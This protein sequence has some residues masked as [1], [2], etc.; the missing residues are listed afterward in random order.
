[1]SRISKQTSAVAVFIVIM[2]SCVVPGFGDEGALIDH[3]SP[4][5][6]PPIAYFTFAPEYPSTEAEITYDASSSYS[7]FGQIAICEWD[8]GDGSLGK[9]GITTHSY[10]TAGEYQVTLTVTDSLEEIAT[11]TRR[12][13][14]AQSV[15]GDVNRDMQIRSNDVVMV[16][17]IAA[18]LS[19]PTDYQKWAADING[20]GEIGV[21][22]A[23]LILRKVT[24]LA[25]PGIDGT[26]ATYDP[27]FSRSVHGEFGP[28][29]RRN[30]LLQNFP[31]PFNPETWIPY[32]LAEGSE[33][34][35]CIYATTG[36]IVRQLDV[37]YRAGGRYADRNSAAYW[38]GRNE[39]GERIASGVYFY[40]IKAG[41]FYTTR[42]MTV[43]Q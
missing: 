4:P 39:L 5:P 2:S 26:M 30:V 21:N 27:N 11:I 15:K 20:D 3:L 37:G 28:Y 22:D 24:G 31:N 18:E 1:M 12:V 33:M 14:V 6:P 36:E 23:V 16:L 41:E 17:L 38:D 40:S 13:A 25:A 32:Q 34:T 10:S 43:S 19:V 9:G 29:I 42:K 7:P 35:I 8:F